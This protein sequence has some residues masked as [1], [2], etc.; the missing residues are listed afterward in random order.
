MVRTATFG[1][2]G[3]T[4]GCVALCYG[5][6]ASAQKEPQR[7]GAV[8]G[9]K[10]EKIAEYKR[11]HTGDNVTV[12]D[13]LRKAHLSNNSIFLHEIDG[14]WYEFSYWEYVGEDYEADM[15][16]LAAEPRYQAWLKVCDAM[17][18]PL[19]GEKGWATMERVYFGP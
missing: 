18:I 7:F 8:I 3:L 12:R 19:K 6:A 17:Q 13:L 4:V 11:L 9:I 14:K 2:V 16:A 15:A 1:I 10:P 5:F